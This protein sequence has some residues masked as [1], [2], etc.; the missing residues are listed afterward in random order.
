MPHR[1]HQFLWVPKKIHGEKGKFEA[2]EKLQSNLE[3]CSHQWNWM[4]FMHRHT[5]F[6][7]WLIDV[8]E[9]M[10]KEKILKIAFYHVQP[11][12]INE[13][14]IHRPVPACVWV[15][16]IVFMT[17]IWSI[18]WKITPRNMWMQYM[19]GWGKQQRTQRSEIIQKKKERNWFS[20]GKWTPT[21]LDCS[22]TIHASRARKKNCSIEEWKVYNIR[23]DF[24]P[25]FSSPHRLQC[26]K[27]T[28]V[29]C[30][31]RLLPSISTIKWIES[32]ETLATIN[33][34]SHNWK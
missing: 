31:R 21:K 33:N 12:G 18:K 11:K 10:G 7:E 4:K 23:I 24:F 13:F 27:W 34:P 26:C 20:T 25:I 2:S 9:K 17:F 1:K 14:L 32:N 3:I 16:R 8:L 29:E 30:L 15:L 6:S 19:C 5:Q 28:C 22:P